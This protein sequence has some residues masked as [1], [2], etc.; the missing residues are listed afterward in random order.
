MGRKTEK[1]EV[2]EALEKLKEALDAL[3]DDVEVLTAGYEYTYGGPAITL[4]R[5]FHRLMEMGVAWS[6][7]KIVSDV[8]AI[9]VTAQYHG[10]MVKEY[11]TP[12]TVTFMFIERALPE[13]AEA[14]KKR[15]SNSKET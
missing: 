3:P 10:V 11:A 13:E 12:G 1:Q 14:A 8:K 2:S 9:L 15:W 7:E 5:S 4:Y 6:T